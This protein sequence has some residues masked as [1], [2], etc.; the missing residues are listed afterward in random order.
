MATKNVTNSAQEHDEEMVSKESKMTHEEWKREFS[1]RLWMVVIA[2][3]SLGVTVG[4]LIG[5]ALPHAH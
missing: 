3:M 5:H 4:V 1:K 2:T